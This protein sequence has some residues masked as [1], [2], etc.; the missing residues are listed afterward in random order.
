M[1][2]KYVRHFR[3]GDSLKAPRWNNIK[4][5]NVEIITFR[6]VDRMRVAQDEQWRTLRSM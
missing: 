6:D 5:S 4:I 1:A 3:E 2:E